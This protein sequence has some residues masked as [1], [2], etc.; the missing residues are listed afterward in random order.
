MAGINT[1]QRRTHNDNLDSPKCPE[2]RRGYLLETET[3][4][5]QLVCSRCEATWSFRLERIARLEP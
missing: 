2:C 1:L 4:A 5:A 3:A